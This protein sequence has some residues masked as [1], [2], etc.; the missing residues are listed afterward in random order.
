M[1][2][3]SMS[4]ERRSKTKSVP[5]AHG[6]SS[7]VTRDVAAMSDARFSG[8]LFS[9]AA[10]FVSTNNEARSDGQRVRAVQYVRSSSD[11]QHHSLENQVAAITEYADQRGYEIVATFVDVGKS[12][13]SLKGRHGLQ[14]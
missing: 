4:D 6:S 3:T 1:V 14:Q 13:L 8:E 9:A 2:S 5:V 7:L 12:G 11:R 10:N